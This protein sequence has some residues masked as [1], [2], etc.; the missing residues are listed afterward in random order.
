MSQEKRQLQ[1]ILFPLEAGWDDSRVSKLQC[2]VQK[3]FK[4]IAHMKVHSSHK[5]LTHTFFE[6]P[7]P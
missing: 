4:N 5:F 2:G 3:H 1:Y 7:E 6:N